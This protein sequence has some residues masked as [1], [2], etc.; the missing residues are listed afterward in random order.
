MIEVPGT[1]I[2]ENI[3]QT[4]EVIT[5][6]YLEDMTVIPRPLPKK[7]KG[8]HRVK[9]PW[10]VKNSVFRDY[11]PDNELILTKCFEIDWG[12]SKISKIIKDEREKE[13]VKNYLRA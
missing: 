7:I 5:S 3:I 10:D 6:A 13:Q 2:V 12:N 8:L 11:I 1:N 4:R 9:T